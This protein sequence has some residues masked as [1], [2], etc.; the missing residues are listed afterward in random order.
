M[1]PWVSRFE[2]GFVRLGS[3][4]SLTLHVVLHTLRDTSANLEALTRHRLT[5]ICACKRPLIW[6]GLKRNERG[7]YRF[8]RSFYAHKQDCRDKI[9]F[10]YPEE[11]IH[12]S[13]NHE[14]SVFKPAHPHNYTIKVKACSYTVTLGTPCSFGRRTR[15]HVAIPLKLVITSLLEQHR[16]P[17]NHKLMASGWCCL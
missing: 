4:L 5:S 13:E 3:D 6:A 9:I 11:T 15:I 12:I 2:T 7:F 10:G 14:K 17:N 8:D 16:K 1:W